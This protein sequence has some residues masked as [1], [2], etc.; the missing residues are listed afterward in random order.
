MTALGGG[1]CDCGADAACALCA[2]SGSGRRWHAYL[3]HADERLQLLGSGPRDFV[4]EAAREWVARTPLPVMTQVV[5]SEVHA[6]A[7]PL[8]FLLRKNAAASGGSATASTEAEVR[9]GR[10]FP[11]DA[12][13]EVVRIGWATY[14]FGADNEWHNARTGA[15]ETR[16]ALIKEARSAN[17]DWYRLVPETD[18]PSNSAPSE[19]APRYCL[20]CKLNVPPAP[21]CTNCGGETIPRSSNETEWQSLNDVPPAVRKVK[22]VKGYQWVRH[23]GNSE[24]LGCDGSYAVCRIGH[25]NLAPFV[26]AEG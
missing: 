15:I 26:A 22:D 12:F 9:A 4:V 20:A 19:P 5:V 21:Y 3:H 11:A 1:L 23:E 8:A 14:Y 2:G 16:E 25:P 10:E 24:W 18:S 7:D 13:G 6:S 17:G